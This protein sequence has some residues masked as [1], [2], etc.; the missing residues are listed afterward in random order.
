MARKPGPFLS[1]TGGDWILHMRWYDYISNDEPVSSQPHLLYA[2]EG[3]DY[4]VMMPDSLMMSS[5][6]RYS[7]PAAKLLPVITQLEA[8]LSSEAVGL[9]AG[10]S[11]CDKS[12][13]RDATAEHFAS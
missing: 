9:A 11:F 3:L 6:T 7:G 1:L 5:Q 10:R 4:S 13:W 2:N 8:C 12:Q